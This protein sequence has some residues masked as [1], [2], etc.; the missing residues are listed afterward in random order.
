MLIE[1]VGA[2]A[3]V[4]WRFRRT[5]PKV[6]ANT[7]VKSNIPKRGLYLIQAN[8]NTKKKI[9]EPRTNATI[10]TANPRI[11]PRRVPIKGIHEINDIIGEKKR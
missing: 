9:R 4:F 10:N 2:T 8:A 1:S 5:N 6:T 7:A 11:Y 3:E